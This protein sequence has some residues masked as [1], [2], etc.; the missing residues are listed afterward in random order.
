[1]VRTRGP[2]GLR[3]RERNSAMAVL[4]SIVRPASISR[5]VHHRFQMFG[6]RDAELDTNLQRQSLAAGDCGDRLEPSL[7]I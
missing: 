3:S 2:R 7:A 5:W 1:M 6:K 4:A